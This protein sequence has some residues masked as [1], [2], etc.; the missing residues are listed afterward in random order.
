VLAGY[1]TGA[2]RR[3]LVVMSVIMLLLISL[4]NGVS[5]FDKDISEAALVLKMVSVSRF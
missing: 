5:N 2:V 4:K 1:G 3:Y